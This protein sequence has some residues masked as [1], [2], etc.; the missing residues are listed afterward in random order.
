MGP[1]EINFSNLL[2]LDFRRLERC[3]AV[4]DVHRRAK[5]KFVESYCVYNNNGQLISQVS[6]F[7]PNDES[8]AVGEATKHC[9]HLIVLRIGRQPPVGLLILHPRFIPHGR[10]TGSWGTFRLVK[11]PSPRFTLKYRIFRCIAALHRQPCVRTRRNW[12]NCYYKGSRVETQSTGIAVIAKKIGIMSNWKNSD[13]L[14]KSGYLNDQFFCKNC[15]FPSNLA[16]YLWKGR[17]F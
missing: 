16:E 12:V 1:F 5:M 10:N 7:Q 11:Q 4:L 3:P 15:P 17:W 8:V 2:L 13:V 6:L 14:S 9:D